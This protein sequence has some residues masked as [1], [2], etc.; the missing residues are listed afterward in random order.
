MDG[1]SR[2]YRAG[3]CFPWQPSAIHTGGAPAFLIEDIS[4]VRVTMTDKSTNDTS[5]LTL[6]ESLFDSI[7]ASA[8]ILRSEAGRNFHKLTP[9]ACCLGF[10]YQFEGIPSRISYTFSQMMIFQQSGYIQIFKG[11]SVVSF[12][13][14]E[15]FFM[16]EIS[17]LTRNFLMLLCDKAFSFLSIFAFQ[18]LASKI[19][20]GFLQL[21]L[22]FAEQFRVI[23][24]LAIGERG[25]VFDANI[26][27]GSLACLGIVWRTVFINSEDHKPAISLTLDRAGFDRSFNWAREKDFD[28]TYFGQMKLI[29]GKIITAFAARLRIGK[30]V[31]SIFAFEAREAGFFRAF[32]NTAKEIIHR[33]IESLQ[34]VLNN[35]GIYF[36]Q[37]SACL[38]NLRQL[39]GLILVGNRDLG[40]AVSVASFLQARIIKLAT[41][42]QSIVKL[43][44][45]IFTW[46]EFKFVSFQGKRTIPLFNGE[47]NKIACINQGLINF[48]KVDCAASP[49]TNSSMVGVLRRG[50]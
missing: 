15:R 4:G 26:N 21:A 31:V 10:S 46:L 1:D 8:T 39:L 22:C 50:I 34:N 44:L 43:L 17:A 24:H 3:S 12:H 37:I 47:Y 6:R 35:L 29:A 49:P 7:T 13:Q 18:L 11:N 33:S 45:D 40:M 9:G 38:F 32:L 27:S 5:M 20:L 36:L 14:L 19:A 28:F 25:K 30:A 16:M 2:L 41:N 48:G 23:N 42:I